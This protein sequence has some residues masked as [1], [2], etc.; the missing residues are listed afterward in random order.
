MKCWIFSLCYAELVVKLS[1]NSGSKGYFLHCLKWVHYKNH[2]YEKFQAVRH[3]I[4]LTFNRKMA[5]KFEFV[6]C[7]FRISLATEANCT[8][9]DLH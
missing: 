9:S 4:F 8:A 2:G 1:S 3:R 6:F 7:P 5:F